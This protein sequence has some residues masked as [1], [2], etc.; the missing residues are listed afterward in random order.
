M[1]AGC[2]ESVKFQPGTQFTIICFIFT[3]HPC[4]PFNYGPIFNGYNVIIFDFALNL[5]S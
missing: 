4:Y 3:L 5:N 1:I 2:E